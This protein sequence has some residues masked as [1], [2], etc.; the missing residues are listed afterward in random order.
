MTAVPSVEPVRAARA[1]RL[2]YTT[3]RQRGFRRRRAGHGFQYFKGKGRTVRGAEIVARIRAL[4]IP[5]AW[6]DVWISADPVGHLQATGRDARGRKQYRYHPR[7][8]TIRDVTKFLRMVDFGAALPS[9]RRRV[10]R[11]LRRPGLPRDKVLAIVVRLLETTLIRVGNE[12]YAQSNGSYGLTTLRDRHALVR[13]KEL[14]FRFPGK[15]GKRHDVTVTDPR[16]ARLVRRCRELSGQELFQY[17]DLD[18]DPHPI[19]SSDVNRYLAETT[20]DEFTAKDFRTWAGTLLLSRRLGSKEPGMGRGRAALLSAVKEVAEE[21][22]NTPAICRRCYVHP[23]ML[24]AFEDDALHEAWCRAC[25]GK[26]RPML[27]GEESALLRFLERVP[28]EAASAATSD[29]RWRGRAIRPAK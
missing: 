16:L 26:K 3:D 11:D 2:H 25:E 22:R 15:G 5:P 7:W 17:L 1:A 18:G 23:A 20:G 13:G 19:T 9:I 4:A 27:S 10:R 12:A 8:R 14:T 21:L 29:G 24:A 6:T 28:A